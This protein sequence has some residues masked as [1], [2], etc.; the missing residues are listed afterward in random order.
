MMSNKVMQDLR[1]HV[2]INIIADKVTLEMKLKEDIL[3][4]RKYASFFDVKQ[5][6]FVCHGPYG[7]GVAEKKDATLFNIITKEPIKWMSFKSHLYAV[8][9][10]LRWAIL[11]VADK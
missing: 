10:V 8:H 7:R 11:G 1:E 5:G 3:L 6:Y 4:M 2:A 9:T